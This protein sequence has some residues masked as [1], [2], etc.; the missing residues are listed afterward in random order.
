MITCRSIGA[1]PPDDVI[2]GPDPELKLKFVCFEVAGGETVGDTEL[3]ELPPL[4]LP[5]RIS[6]RAEVKA[7]FAK[8][9]D[10]NR[11]ERSEDRL[12]GIL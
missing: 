8:Q 4:L 1:A 3:L 12:V 5:E 11:C 7:K 2:E 9:G 6:L 10:P